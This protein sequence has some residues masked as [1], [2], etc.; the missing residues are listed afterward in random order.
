MKKIQLLNLKLVN[1]KGIKEFELNANG[2]DLNVFGE[3][4][5]GKTTLFD[6]FVWLLFDKDSANRSAGKM[7][8]K[9][10]DE[11]GNE[12]HKLNH[13]VQGVLLIDGQR[14]TLKKIYEEKWTKQ[15]GAEQAEHT[16]HTTNY[17]IDEVPSKRKEY[18]EFIKGIVD[19]NI[20]KLLTNPKYFNEVLNDNKRR[21]LLLEV[22]GDITD[23]DVFKSDEKLLE[24]KEAL[25]NRTV[26]KHKEMVRGKLTEINKELDRIPIRIDEINRGLP[27]T[28]GLDKTAITTKL[29]NLLNN[30]ESKNEQI[31]SIKNGS[32]TNALKQKISE[33]ELSLSKVRNEHTQNEQ[34][35]LFKLKTR[36]QE[37]QS[38]LGILRNDLRGQEQ[39]KQSNESRVKDFEQ[40]MSDLRN[41]WKEHNA[42]QF[43][44]ESECSCPT[45]G[46]DLPEEQ[47]EETK[48]KFNKNKSD[49][50]EK[51]NA[52]GVELKNKVEELQQENEKLQK[53]IDKITEQG[54]KKASD[55]ERLEAK[56]KEAESTV[57]PVEDNPDYVK[58]NEEKQSLEQ[59]IKQLEQSVDSSAL[60]VKKEIEALKEQQ[61]ALQ[62]DLSKLSQLEQSK[63]RINELENQEKTLNEEY[64]QLSK[65]LFLTEEFTRTKVNMLENSIN[66]KFKYARFKLFE[67]QINGGLRE[68]CETTF[69]G[70]P[71]SSGLNNAA[72]INVGLDIINTLS[73]HY[74]VQAPIF[75]DN[76]ESVTR[77]ID[78]D[79]QVISLIVSE[80]DK[81]LRV[82]SKAEKEVA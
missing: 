30:I 50:L 23:E 18:E 7:G 26:E 81:Q 41:Q 45:C 46:Q 48:A 80:Q 20:F 76:A 52:K 5:T 56:I 42:L 19:E 1:F 55:I 14:V 59:Q 11:Q 43:D 10:K 21:D 33:I 72:Q 8:I 13:E 65:E 12:F 51:V 35:E 28:N 36:L 24:L 16:G 58:L 61:S 27:D 79:S 6:A 49:L 47:L 38:N 77:L 82:E 67:Q 37:E 29:D 34:Q 40:Q 31:N 60:D 68:V 57:K 25:G 70:V 62:M 66:N 17:F 4:G 32:E 64:E 71:Y 53:D 75:V 73:T 74:G 22:A 3:N 63:E 2:K 15:R 69:E 78:I 44:H 9:T 54:K 39:Q